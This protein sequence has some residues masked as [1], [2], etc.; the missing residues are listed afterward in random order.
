MILA[1]VAAAGAA[2]VAVAA[3]VQLAGATAAAAGAGG[4]ADAGAHGRARLVGARAALGGGIHAATGLAVALIAALVVSPVPAALIGV[5][6]GGGSVLRAGRAA[7]SRRRACEHGTPTLARSVA[8]ALRGGASIRSAVREA[9][10]DRS[11]PPAL[12]EELCAA[13][14]AIELGTPLD[15]VLLRL[16]GRG[17][18]GLRLA[19]GTISM[20]LESGGA[21]ATA[22]ERVAIDGEA[23]LRVEE[24]RLAATAQARAT[25]RVVAA[26][27]V[28]ALLGAELTSGHF[29]AGIVAKPVSLALLVAGLTLEALAVVAARAIVGRR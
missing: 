7:R 28:L 21:L 11:V 16:A 18:P 3:V 4:L 15:A 12:R 17:G 13:S 26:L 24:E 5:L 27:P 1:V 22:L 8:D 10:A 25:V 23:A 19:C 14:S 9:A 20:H 2:V 29:V 6:A